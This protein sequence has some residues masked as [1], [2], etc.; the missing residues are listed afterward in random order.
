MP[1][2]GCCEDQKLSLPV[3]PLWTV[4]SCNQIQKV[5]V[6][7]HM[8]S[9]LLRLLSCSCSCWWKRLRSVDS[10]ISW[11][12]Y[13]PDTLHCSLFS[14]FCFTLVSWDRCSVLPTV[15]WNSGF[16]PQPPSAPGFLTIYWMRSFSTSALKNSR[17]KS[18]NPLCFHMRELREERSNLPALEQ[19]LA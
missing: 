12:L 16:L 13:A 18:R 2:S 10:N 1:S 17:T 3:S 14:C 5:Y 19:L 6:G 15:V 7:R 4:H 8:P 9:L 11:V